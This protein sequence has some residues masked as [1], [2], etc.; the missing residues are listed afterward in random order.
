MAVTL[1]S[2]FIYVI[3]MLKTTPL[4]R[5][6]S[7]FLCFHEAYEKEKV[8]TLGLSLTIPLAVFGDFLLGRSTTIIG[9]IGA[10][11]V[12][13]S[14]GI[15][16]IAARSEQPPEALVRTGDIE[17]SF[18]DEGDEEPLRGRSR[19]RPALDGTDIPQPDVVE[20]DR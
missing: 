3:A 2:D 19:I 7:I 8:V 11:L 13:L 4:V 18:E 17:G 14:F 9:L 15:I 10:V 20:T 1:S 12:L 5:N 16:G 6:S